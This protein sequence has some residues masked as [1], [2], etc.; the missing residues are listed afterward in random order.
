M[1]TAGR[2]H[3]GGAATHATYTCSPHSFAFMRLEITVANPKGTDPVAIT[4][5]TVKLQIASS[6]KQLFGTVGVAA[7]NFDVLSVVADTTTHA[8][9]LRVRQESVTPLWTALAL[10]TKFDN[11]PCKYE[12]TQVASSLV[13]LASPRYL[14]V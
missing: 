9:L 8:A 10:S 2:V 13:E 14:D 6:I 7:H 4:P 11:F 12:A 3:G 5:T 1:P